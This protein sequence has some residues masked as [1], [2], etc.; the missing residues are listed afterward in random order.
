MLA[1]AVVAGAEKLRRKSSGHLS[2]SLVSICPM[3]TYKNWKR[4]RKPSTGAQLLLMNDG[5]YQEQEMVDDL[6]RA[7]FEVRSRQMEVHIGPMRGFIDGLILVDSKWCLLDCKAMSLHRYTAFK[8]RGFESE[9]SIKVQMQLY[10][11][12]NELQKEGIDS[13]FIYAKHKDSCRPYDLYFEWDPGF[14]HKMEEQVHSLL[15]ELV[16]TPIR[17]SL[18]S[19]CRDRLECW[20]AEVVDFSGVHMSSLPGLVEQWKLGTNYKR[21]GKELVE[22][23]R[24]AFKKELGDKPVVFIDDLKVLRI[25]PTRGGISQI[26]FVEKYGAAALTEVWEEKKISQM[27][28]TEVEL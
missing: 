2:P 5:H 13:G 4:T 23:A 7:G 16:P 14:S 9:S 26:K 11:A 1:E 22:E 17:C 19:S 28:V 10:L 12:S 20:G 25:T 21:Y 3:K 24:V 27:K 15:G 8:Q 18:C 6:I